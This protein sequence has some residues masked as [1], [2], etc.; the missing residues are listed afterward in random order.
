MTTIVI[1]WV[2][3]KLGAPVWVWVL[4]AIDI[5]IGAVAEMAK[6]GNDK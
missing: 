6:Q 1:I 5:A 2:L 4:L 3:W